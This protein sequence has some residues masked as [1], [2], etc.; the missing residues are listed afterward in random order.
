MKTYHVDV[1]VTVT[2]SYEVVATDEDHAFD[3]AHDLAADDFKEHT[4][5]EIEVNEITELDKNMDT[6]DRE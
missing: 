4:N 5:K 3:R 2:T 1:T 6:D